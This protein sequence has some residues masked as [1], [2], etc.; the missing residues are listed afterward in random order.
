MLN[1]RENN[2]IAFAEIEDL[3]Y[4]QIP[5]EKMKYEINTTLT[6]VTNQQFW[7]VKIFGWLLIAI[8][9]ALLCMTINE[10]SKHLH[11]QRH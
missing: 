2:L 10:I 5:A 6:T 7:I 1:D 11:L 4:S 8:I 3:R 9:I